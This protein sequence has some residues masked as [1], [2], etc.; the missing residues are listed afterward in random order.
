MRKHILRVAGCGLMLVWL[1]QIATAQSRLR[2][3]GQRIVNAANQEVILK[4]VGLG[5]W[6]LQEGYMLK[7]EFTGGGTQWS[8]KKRLYDQGQSE[9]AVEAFYQSWR[10]NF[11]TKADIDFIAA[12]G[13]NCVRLPMHY[14]LFLT[15]AQ[16]SVRNSVIRDPANINNY[17]NSLSTWYDQNQLFN[18]P[19]N[20]EGFRI[21][22]RL[23]GWCAA[24]NMYVIL[25]LH[26][27]P[28]GQGTDA[29]IADVLVQND[30]WYRRDSQNR[31]IYQD[32]TVRLW[33]RIAQR[34]I[35][36]D[37]VA[38]YDF[39][40]EPNNVPDNRWIHDI[41]ERLINAVRAL[42]DTHLILI[43]GNGWGNN[44]NYMEPYTFTN[45]SN[46]VYS[47][48]RYW[49]T[50][51]IT[52]REA[53][54][55][56]QINLIG[57]LVDFRANHNVPVWVSETGENSDAWLRENAQN[58]LTQGI[59]FLHWTHK[60]T[61]STPNAALLRI[62]PPYILD[63]A[64]NMSAVLENIKFVNNVPNPGPI[65]AVSPN[66]LGTCAYAGAPSTIQAETYCTMSGVQIESTTDGGANG[67]S[68]GFIDTGDWM[69][70][71]INVPVSGTYTMQY[72]VASQSGGGVIRLETYGGGSVLGTVNVPAT[73]G[74]QTWQ[75]ISHTVQ[76]NAGQQQIAIAVPTG[77]FNLNWFSVSAPPVQI[78]I[79]QTI[80][81]RGNNN[82]YVSSENGTAAMQCTRTTASSW[83]QFTVVDAGGGKV[84]LRSM[85][86][87]VSSE[88]GTAAI[89]CNRTTIGDWEKFDWIVNADGKISLRGNNG[90]YIS[91]ENGAAA[92][93]CNR[94]AI[95]GW[96]AFNV[97]VVSAAGRVSTGAVTPVAPVSKNEAW[98]VY[99]NPA[100]G[101]LTV[102][103]PKPAVVT[104]LNGNGKAVQ[105]ANVNDRWEVPHLSPGLYIIKYQS[106][107]QTEIRKVIVE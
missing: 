29:N 59:G 35:N 100:R 54:N 5:G 98:T 33:Q 86:K 42:G 91:S 79:G 34:Y 97:G 81:L 15:S 13:F 4:G 88:N 36:D 90:R 63:G 47:A 44:Y 12:Q 106:G 78:P 3:D 30:L 60:R 87:Y 105:Q 6:V 72:R 61:S 70:Y 71:R 10:D 37:R 28:G 104:V 101:A 21:I 2:A 66:N 20:L 17:V 69:S 82:L 85:D 9:A 43:E 41:F 51:D 93:T 62:N 8:V 50:N 23:L 96:E 53:N 95:S 24:N 49:V 31:L 52:A 25:D 92:M 67:F 68:V 65:A 55:A 16:R 74:W 103:V 75:T 64:A 7:P 1:A 83:E 58:L 32:I 39:I 57:N 89:T 22:D 73:G 14:E 107:T 48:H 102:T 45:R 26:A 76:L 18:D 56:N 27:L 77:G 46:L 84:A 94:T 40:N 19:A 11:I 99:P 80:S 38:M